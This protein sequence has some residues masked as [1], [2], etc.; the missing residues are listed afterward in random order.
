MQEV[1]GVIWFKQRMSNKS[2]VI[3]MTCKQDV[4]E[5]D[6]SVCVVLKCG[7]LICGVC[8]K[9]VMYRNSKETIRATTSW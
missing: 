9:A 3:F 7:G 2:V 8:C 6:V 5:Q 1:D 4:L